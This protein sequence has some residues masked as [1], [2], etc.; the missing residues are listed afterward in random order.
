MGG[1]SGV[2]VLKNLLPSSVRF[3]REERLGGCV[4][5]VCT[6]AP[7]RVSLKVSL[8]NTKPPDLAA[9]HSAEGPR[10]GARTFNGTTVLMTF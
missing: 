2:G 4:V 3:L 10:V 6:R 7:P 1:R 9:G 5:A 8:G